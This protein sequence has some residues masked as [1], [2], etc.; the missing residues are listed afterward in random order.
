M[1]RSQALF[2]SPSGLA[3]CRRTVSQ[4][5]NASNFSDTLIRT[6]EATRPVALDMAPGIIQ[7]RDFITLAG[8][9]LA[10]P[11]AARA[12]Q[13]R[14]RILYLTHSAGY[15]HEVIPFSQSVLEQLGDNS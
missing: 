5:P 7:R 10:W 15:R 13:R 3:R 12:Q 11:L 14:E 1:S 9:A 4:T 8:A 6:M 2:A